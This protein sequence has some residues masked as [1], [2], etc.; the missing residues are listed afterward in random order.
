MLT[1]SSRNAA[2]CQAS[3][4][5]SGD[6]AATGSQVVDPPA[7][8]N[9]FHIECTGAG[10]STSADALVSVEL[11]QYLVTTVSLWSTTAINDAGGVSGWVGHSQGPCCL[12]QPNDYAAWTSG[13]AP[14]LPPP[15]AG[16]DPLDA[17]GTDPITGGSNCVSHAD[18]INST[19]EVVVSAASVYN[20]SL[21]QFVIH[22]G[23]GT[24]TVIAGLQSASAINDSDMIVGQTP[25][26]HAGVF[27]DGATTDLGTLGGA[28]SDATAVNNSGRVVGNAWTSTDAHERAFLSD[29]AGLVDLGD[30]GGGDAQ[31]NAVNDSGV[32]VGSSSTSSADWHAF[33]F[34]DNTMTDIG[35]AAAN[36]SNWGATGINNAGLIVG[37]FA[38]Q[39]ATSQ[40]Q[41]H[42]VIY[43]NGTF[44]D[45]MSIVT[46][47]ANL[48]N[49]PDTD[50]YLSGYPKINN[51]G[52]IAIPMCGGWLSAGHV[53]SCWVS[54]LTPP[55]K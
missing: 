54:I 18:G 55:A 12:Y 37:E 20:V 33:R 41:Y 48:P 15:P 3:G 25:S 5:W 47:P 42:P 28:D 44:F 46:N 22:Y 11:P 49:G 32:V 21:G 24:A 26:G 35:S 31:A 38:P 9:D 29:G 6:L 1:W 4:Q 16:Q 17:C 19:G 30:L 50:I 2:A 51:H 10:G 14:P 27:A 13:T 53:D 34:A 7:A 40:T 45:L 36:N 39:G 43:S 23:P 52:Q 8:H